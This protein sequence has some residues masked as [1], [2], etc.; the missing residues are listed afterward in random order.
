MVKSSRLSSA[1]R[2]ASSPSL[3]GIFA[4]NPTTSTEQRIKSSG[5]S[6]NSLSFLKKSFVSF[7]NDLFF[8]DNDF[9]WY[10]KKAEMFYKNTLLE[11]AGQP[12]TSCSRL[13][14]LGNK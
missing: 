1:F 14:I 2:M 5:K 11:I 12:G 6:R 13:W 7:I 9:K 10:S 3:C 8:W 4:Y